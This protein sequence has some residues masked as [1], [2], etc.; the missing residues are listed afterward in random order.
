[1]FA[2]SMN[3]FG[4]AITFARLRELKREARI[5]PLVEYLIIIS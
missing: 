5:S 2:G 1:M 4:C 3:F